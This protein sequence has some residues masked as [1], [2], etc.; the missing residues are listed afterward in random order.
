M[1]KIKEKRK[2]RNQL[3]ASLFR[4]TAQSISNNAMVL[5]KTFSE[6]SENFPEKTRV[7][8]KNRMLS[9]KINNQFARIPEN[10][11]SQLLTTFS[12]EYSGCRGG[13]SRQT[14][15]PDSVIIRKLMTAQSCGF[16]PCCSKER[17]PPS[18]PSPLFSIFPNSRGPG[19]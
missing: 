3:G 16:K 10:F 11:R 17:I 15:Q 9:G 19:I 8:A 14:R 1:I 6:S 4:V 2:R 7:S 12:I 18:A 13:G 5:F